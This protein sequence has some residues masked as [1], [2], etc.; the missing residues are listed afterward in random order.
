M[1]G[2]TEI[3]T[4]TVAR[5]LADPSDNGNVVGDRKLSAWVVCVES[6]AKEGSSRELLRYEYRYREF[7]S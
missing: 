4:T 3:M 5:I 1:K 7:W 2:N 6:P